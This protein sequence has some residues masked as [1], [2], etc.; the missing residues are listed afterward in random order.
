M[1]PLF[2]AYYNLGREHQGIGKTPARAAGIDSKLGYDKW[3]RLIKRAN[4][5]KKTG[6]KI[7]VW[8]TS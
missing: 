8:D 2:T 6:G 4:K 7:R 1:I 3:N 5:H